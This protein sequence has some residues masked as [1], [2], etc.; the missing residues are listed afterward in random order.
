MNT[1][2]TESNWIELGKT[3]QLKEKTL[4]QIVINKTKIALSYKDGKFYAVS[5]VCN[6]SGG[7]IGEGKI[8]GDY[9]VCPWHYWKFHYATGE[10]EPGFEDDKIP[11]YKLKE[12]NGNLYVDENSATKRSKKPHAPHPLSRKA[13]REGGSIRFVGISTTVMNKDYP[14]YSTSD[15]LLNIAIEYAKNAGCETKLISLNNLQFR[16]CEGYYS[17]SARAC[18]WPCSITQMDTNDEMVKVY[19][20]FV[21]WGDAFIISTPI[22][23]GA[24]SSLYYKMIERMNCIQNQETIANKILLKNK[25]VSFIITGGQDNI[26]AVAGQMLGFFAEIGC[27]FPQFPYIAHSRGWSAE[28]MENNMRYVMESK[29]LKEGTHALVDRTIK[30]ANKMI[31]G[32]MPEIMT[33][34]GGRKAHELDVKAQI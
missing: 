11:I 27:Q 29:S 4:Q 32:E 7:P 14:R 28:D 10:G 23:W 22:R 33:A 25:T 2:K 34:R 20:A 9:I 31:S 13:N 6:H 21:H 18:T 19:E 26:Q 12:E 8:E 16:N 1:N 3:D 15:A 17:K 24:A 5:G 30:M